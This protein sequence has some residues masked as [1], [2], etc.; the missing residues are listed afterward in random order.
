[1][2]KTILFVSAIVALAMGTMLSSCNKEKEIVPPAGQGCYCSLYDGGTFAYT[3]Y[4]YLDDYASDGAYNC[5][6][7][8][9][10]LNADD[11]DYT[12]KCS[13]TK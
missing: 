8:A 1:M 3:V 11:D 5:T 12:Y 10:L 6:S 13:S 9:A 7:L 2:K 4:V